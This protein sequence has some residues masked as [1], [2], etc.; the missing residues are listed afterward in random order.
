MKTRLFVLLITIQF[1]ALSQQLPF[2]RNEAYA[3]LTYN[4][5]S[6][7]TWNDFSVNLSGQWVQFPD[8]LSPSAAFSSELFPPVFKKGFGMGTGFYYLFDHTGFIKLHAVGLPVNGQAK[9]GNTF[10]S[11]G[12]AP[13]FVYRSMDTA[14]IPPTT[15]ID[16]NIPSEIGQA[17]FNL[18]AGIMLYQQEWYGGI[19]MNQ[20]NTPYF[21]EL[22]FD[23]AL[24]LFLH[25]GYRLRVAENKQ[26]FPSAIIGF[27]APMTY[28]F[29]GKMMLQ[30][31]N[32]GISFGLGYSSGNILSAIIAYDLKNFNV[33]MQ[34][35]TNG[36]IAETPFYNVYELRLSYRLQK[37]FSCSACQERQN[38]L[39]CEHGNYF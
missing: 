1:V 38:K 30:F 33:M 13:E 15:V 27:V 7:G 19:S 24:H 12:I 26:L 21:N 36:L 17:R 35:G 39:G 25:A 3:P 29:H 34:A 2:L 9:I 11:V 10:L 14:F 8:D 6:F 31:L 22:N 23:A 4:P 5:A 18:N 32:P 37:P 28:S 16:P 20:L